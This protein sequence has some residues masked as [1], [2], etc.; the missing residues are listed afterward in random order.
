METPI[1]MIVGRSIANR[2][3]CAL[4]LLPSTQL[5]NKHLFLYLGSTDLQNHRQRGRIMA[6]SILI[7]V[8][9]R[10]GVQKID[11]F[12][13][14]VRRCSWTQKEPFMWYALGLV[15]S[16]RNKRAYLI[17][18]SASI[19]RHSLYSIIRNKLSFKAVLLM[20][21]SLRFS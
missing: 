21:S 12:L 2:P 6:L 14:S 1:L 20:T 16:M 17:V 13:P 5:T 10:S 15:E 4:S 11:H 19:I 18:V 9:H 8:W 3:T 7:T